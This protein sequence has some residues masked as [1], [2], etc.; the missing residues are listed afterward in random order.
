MDLPKIRQISLSKYVRNTAKS[1]RKKKTKGLFKNP[2]FYFALTA[3]SL[4][5]LTY[6]A[7]DNLANVDGFSDS[8]IVFFNSFFNN[9]KVLNED[10][11][12]SGQLGQA[13]SESPDFKI[14]QNNTLSAVS[15]PNLVTGKVLGDVLG[16]ASSAQNK[17][18]ITDYVVQPG[19]TLGGIADSYGISVKTILQANQ[20]TSSSV[21]KVGQ[22]L[23]ILPVDG[24]VHAVR[25]GDTVS[26]IAQTYKADQDEIVKF[27][28]LAN[29]GDIYIGDVLIVP[30]GTIQ[31]RSVV[32][33]KQ[34]PLAEN[35]F[36]YPTEGK[37]SQG[38]HYYNAIDIANKCG[39]PIYAAAAG[40]V[41]RAVGNGTWNY[42]MGNHI[43]ILHNNGTV[44]YYG[45]LM[46]LFVKPGD[47][48]SVGQNI[49]LM[50]GRPGMAGAGKSTGCHLH[51]QVVGA[52]NPLAGY[53]LGT[54]VSYK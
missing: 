51:F 44:T 42:G 15:V 41:Q 32:S 36:I 14:I 25:S 22:T 39:T 9:N 4:F 49:A 2:V 5:Q 19:D 31:K 45:H 43:T 35:Y 28:N 16:S 13:A 48:V 38:L 27:N 33:V 50:G 6:A 12:F 37:I 10:A 20:L 24:L 30:G 8:R 11:L 26:A 23:A 1:L 54:N 47:R 3:F 53:A 46:T 40:I 29:K 52:R 17:K 7:S 21:L 34:I 18:Q